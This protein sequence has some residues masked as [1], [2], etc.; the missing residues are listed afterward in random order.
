[1]TNGRELRAALAD[2]SVRY[3]QIISDITLSTADGWSS[4]AGAVV[5]SRLLEVRAMRPPGDTG[6]PYVID[7]GGLV[8]V[9][10]LT[11]RFFIQ[12]SLRLTNMGWPAVLPSNSTGS[13]GSGTTGA[14]NGTSTFSVIPPV[15]ISGPA[16]ILEL[17]GVHLEGGRGLPVGSWGPV[18]A[19]LGLEGVS[20]R[21]QPSLN[22]SVSLAA[23]AAGDLSEVATGLLRIAN[24]QKLGG[25]L[26]FVGTS[27]TWSELA[28]VAPT[29]PGSGGG[30]KGGGGSVPAAAIAVPVAVCVGAVAVLGATLLWL[31][32]RNAARGAHGNTPLVESSDGG[33]GSSQVHPAPGGKERAMEEGLKPQSGD[34]PWGKPGDLAGSSGA[35]SPPDSEQL[36]SAEDGDQGG[37]GVTAHPNGNGAAASTPGSSRP[38]SLQDSADPTGPDAYSG[39]GNA[40][41]KQRGAVSKRPSRGSLQATSTELTAGTTTYNSSTVTAGIQNAAVPL[42][43]GANSNGAGG[44]SRPGSAVSGAVSGRPQSGGYASSANVQSGGNASGTGGGTPGDSQVVFLFQQQ[45]MA[46]SNSAPTAGTP[47][48][49]GLWMGWKARFA[50]ACMHLMGRAHE[51]KAL[52]QECLAYLA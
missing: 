24:P 29:D 30:G 42:L 28:P 32:K 27:V 38:V 15:E 22:A 9:I 11:A 33:S 17:Q 14:A 25:F 13:T 3:I 18:L 8:G 26:S 44:Q 12:G 41:G 49:G 21:S 5:V 35:C 47:N 34:E 39:N 4:G 1:M 40:N 6:G 23:A 51:H 45:S 52:R 10:R 31:R 43:R 19:S 46:N 2:N 20:S 16:A 50:H 48:E 36:R 37:M 7:F